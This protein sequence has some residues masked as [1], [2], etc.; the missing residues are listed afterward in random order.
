MA[1]ILKDTGYRKHPYPFDWLFTDEKVILDIVKDDFKKFL[2][3]SYYGEVVHKFSGR[4]SCHTIYHEDFFFHKDPRNEEDYKYYTKCVDNFRN[5]LKDND[6][7]LFTMIFTPQLTSHP[8]DISEILKN[9]SRDQYEE[10][11]KERLK[12]FND[13]F[14]NYTSNYKLL[15]IFHFSGNDERSFKMVEY[16]D[17]DFLT[18][19][20]IGFSNGAHF[21]DVKDKEHVESIV[22]NYIN[23]E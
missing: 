18:I 11:L 7:K 8:K 4:Q 1:Q 20:T 17:I 23:N 9:N 10:I 2:D 13:E 12:L 16:S 5:L 15:V 21:S 19:N 22:K 6:K 14:K 3:K